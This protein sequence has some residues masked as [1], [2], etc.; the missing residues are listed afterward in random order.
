[1]PHVEEFSWTPVLP[2]SPLAHETLITM[3]G[4]PRSLRNTT[5]KIG[6]K[7]AVRVYSPRDSLRPSPY[8]QVFSLQKVI[9]AFVFETKFLEKEGKLNA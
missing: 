5:W 4:P 2:D 1:M 9:L 8:L 7:D 3:R 6:V